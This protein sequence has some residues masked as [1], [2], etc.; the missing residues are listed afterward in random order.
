MTDPQRQPLRSA[1]AAPN[2]GGVRMLVRARWWRM[3]G[4]GSESALVRSRNL[5]PCRPSF[6]CA[7]SKIVRSFVSRAKLQADRLIDRQN[8]RRHDISLDYTTTE[9]QPCVPIQCKS[10]TEPRA[11]LEGEHSCARGASTRCEYAL[12]VCH[13]LSTAARLIRKRR[14]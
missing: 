9:G 3:G 5:P 4:M 11:D 13:A 14:S 2:V 12:R 6:G 10:E 7:I 8:R 1:F